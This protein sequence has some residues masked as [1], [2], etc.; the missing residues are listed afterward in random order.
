ME[1]NELSNMLSR[2]GA[3]LSEHRATFSALGDPSRQAILVELLNHYGGMRV[4]EIAKAVGLSRPATSHHLKTL[5]E[6]GL[7]DMYEKGTMNFYHACASA[8]EWQAI[9]L[10]AESVSQAAEAAAQRSEAE[11]ESTERSK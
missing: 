5:R 6:A 8:S 9:A 4:N 3:G 2:I 7:A 11:I 1:S 10:L